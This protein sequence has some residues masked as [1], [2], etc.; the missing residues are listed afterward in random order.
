MAV[1]H[2]DLPGLQPPIP[3]DP[4]WEERSEHSPPALVPAERSEF[5]RST[6]G[7]CTASPLCQPCSVCPARLVTP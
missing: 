3:T 6:E 2:P 7:E 1:P 5:A 4:S